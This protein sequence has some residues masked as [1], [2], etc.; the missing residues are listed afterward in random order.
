MVYFYR[1]YGKSIFPGKAYNDILSQNRACNFNFSDDIYKKI[2][3]N[4]K[5]NVLRIF[6]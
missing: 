6:S 3:K 2:S 1:L 4:G 5:Y